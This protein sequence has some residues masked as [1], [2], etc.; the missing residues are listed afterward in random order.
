MPYRR[1]CKKLPRYMDWLIDDQLISHHEVRPSVGPVL[2]LWQPVCTMLSVMQCWNSVLCWTFFIVVNSCL[3]CFA[4]LLRWPENVGPELRSRYHVQAAVK[5]VW[6]GSLVVR[7]S[8]CRSRGCGFEY[9]PFLCRVQ[10]CASRSRTPASVTM[11]CNS[12]VTMK[13]QW[14]SAARKVTGSMASHRPC[15]TDFV[16]YPVA[17]SVL[18]VASGAS[19]MLSNGACSLWFFSQ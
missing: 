11:Q 4:L 19:V 7:A 5:F 3:S 18:Y 10:P 6:L 2:K 17:S 9:H 15:V 14:C 12:V 8:N 1:H 16:L 13:G